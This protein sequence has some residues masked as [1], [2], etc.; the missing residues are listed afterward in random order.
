MQSFLTFLTESKNLHLEHA[1]DEIFNFGADGISEVTNFL[2][3]LQDMLSGNAKSKEIKYSNFR[4]SERKTY[5][6]E[7][8]TKILKPTL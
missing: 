3:S 5:F 1:E 6:Q 4:V 7:E 8:N 2:E